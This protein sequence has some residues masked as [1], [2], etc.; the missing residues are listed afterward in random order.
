MNGSI[1][2]ADSEGK[3]IEQRRP[4]CLPLK[5]SISSTASGSLY[6]PSD[7]NYLTV[8]DEATSEENLTT[9]E[10]AST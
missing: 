7:T 4:K 3:F 1:L 10:A 9:V 6:L 2:Q 8:E 5:A